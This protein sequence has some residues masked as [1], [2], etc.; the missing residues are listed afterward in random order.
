MFQLPTPLQSGPTSPEVPMAKEMI[1]IQPQL[2]A[3][4][5]ALAY[6]QQ[7][8]QQGQQPHV[9]DQF[10][11]MVNVDLDLELELDV[12]GQ[13]V[14]SKCSPSPTI[15]EASE[16][17]QKTRSKS[18]GRPVNSPLPSPPLRPISGAQSC[19]VKRPKQQQQDPQSIEPTTSKD[20]LNTP[21]QSL[22][23]PFASSS[24][25]HLPSPIEENP[26]VKRRVSITVPMPK[27][28]DA[29]DNSQSGEGPSRRRCKTRVAVPVSL[30]LE[31]LQESALRSLNLPRTIPPLDPQRTTVPVGETPPAPHPDILSAMA[32]YWSHFH[33]ASMLQ[34][35]NIPPNFFP[36][37]FPKPFFEPNTSSCCTNCGGQNNTSATHA[38]APNLISPP[39]NDHH[40]HMGSFNKIPNPPLPSR[41]Q[42]EVAPVGIESSADVTAEYLSFL[43]MATGGRVADW[44]SDAFKN[45]VDTNESFSLESLLG[46]RADETE[47]DFPA[48]SPSVIDPD[49]FHDDGCSGQNGIEA[50]GTTSL[51]EFIEMECMQQQPVPMK[52]V[53]SE[54]IITDQSKDK[55]S[56]TSIDNA[57]AGPYGGT[58]MGGPYIVLGRSGFGVKR[59]LSNAQEVPPA[60]LPKKQ[61]ASKPKTSRIAKKPKAAA[62]DEDGM[63][64]EKKLSS[65]R[66]RR[67]TDS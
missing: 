50:M 17:K 13:I 26:I 4:H 52:D 9:Q 7:G 67:V 16:L 20:A 44:G 1:A 28:S 8:Q 25:I 60:P 36:F 59:R 33:I 21:M 63:K 65:Q 12:D 27:Q 14:R 29:P 34:N 11:V 19:R 46:T 53:I 38:P 64:S 2:A 30:K 35:F 6:Q 24:G 58:E 57:V 22:S 15:V 41:A 32:A 39:T 40:N 49:E 45:H 31:D 3:Y 56:E 61:R 62:K 10:Q 66:S 48:H 43:D 47:H 23:V 51:P 37:P 55:A 5:S 42:E 18:M 54:S